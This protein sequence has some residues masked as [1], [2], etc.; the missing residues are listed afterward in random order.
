MLPLKR[1][2]LGGKIP[3]RMGSNEEI[4]FIL[5][6]I[7]PLMAESGMID[8]V[9]IAVRTKKLVSL[10]AEELSK[11]GIAICIIDKLKKDNP[12]MHGVRV[13]TMH[14]V[15]GLEFNTMIIASANKGVIPHNKAIA[16][17]DSVTKKE[18]LKSE[19][20]LLYVLLHGQGRTL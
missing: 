13:A 15:K 12:A 6:F 18:G 8:N 3:F 9:C 20:A 11:F 2:K 17:S 7:K 16:G 1:V 4:G 19:R 5:D 10:Y 14:R